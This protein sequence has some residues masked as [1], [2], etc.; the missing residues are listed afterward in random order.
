MKQIKELRNEKAVAEELARQ[1]EF[2]HRPTSQ[3][4][5]K[6]KVRF[7]GSEELMNIVQYASPQTK[8]ADENK[9]ERA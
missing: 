9:V 4:T 1:I 3:T 2:T 6:C 5:G 7:K 8:A